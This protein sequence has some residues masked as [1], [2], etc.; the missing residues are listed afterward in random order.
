MPGQPLEYPTFR[1]NENNPD[2]EF[3][4]HKPIMHPS[5]ATKPPLM[6]KNQN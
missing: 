4:L 5:P 6:A 1:Q 2:L 3:T